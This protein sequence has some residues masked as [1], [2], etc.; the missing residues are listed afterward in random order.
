MWWGRCSKSSPG[1]EMLATAQLFTGAS[2]LRQVH[3][4]V[5]PEEA[6]GRGR[7][8]RDLLRG[9]R[10]PLT[11]KALFTAMCLVAIAGGG[12]GLHALGVKLDDALLDEIF[13]WFA[14]V[15]FVQENVKEFQGALKPSSGGPQGL[16]RWR[17]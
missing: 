6:P 3:R 7:L 1:Q 11:W 5:A 4:I 2:R 9:L 8:R 14:E 12:N 13:A 15:V 16:A 17:N 10:D